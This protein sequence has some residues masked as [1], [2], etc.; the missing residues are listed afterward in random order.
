[1]PDTTL[2][3][4]CICYSSDQMLSTIVSSSSSGLPVPGIQLSRSAGRAPLGSRRTGCSN[5]HR[6]SSPAIPIFGCSLLLCIS[7]HCELAAGP[8]RDPTAGPPLS[9]ISA[10]A[11]RRVLRAQTRQQQL[12]SATCGC[13]ACPPRACILVGALHS[14]S[15]RPIFCARPCCFIHRAHPC[16]CSFSMAGTVCFASIF[17]ST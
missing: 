15:Q 7:F 2:V 11:T 12:S 16:A 8:E 6:F 9:F 4:T 10:R 5:S 17:Y 13:F 1:M 3:A 14:F